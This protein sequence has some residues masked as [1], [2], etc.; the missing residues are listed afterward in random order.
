[1]FP[2]FLEINKPWE[3]SIRCQQLPLHY[4]HGTIMEDD[5]KLC[6][7][8]GVNVNKKARHDRYNLPPEMIKKKPVRYEESESDS[9]DSTR[10]SKSKKKT[11]KSTKAPIVSA[12]ASSRQTRNRNPKTFAASLCKVMELPDAPDHPFL[13]IFSNAD[14]C[15]DC[16][17]KVKDAHSNQTEM[18]KLQTKLHEARVDF[19]I[20]LSKHLQKIPCVKGKRS[21]ST[22]SNQSF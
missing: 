18:E 22:K 3:L 20:D 10:N 15:P 8:C 1:M 13:Q 14:Y 4:C 9:D 21:P 12:P 7:I 16:M 5:L 11:P 17:A 6:L 2:G 19:E